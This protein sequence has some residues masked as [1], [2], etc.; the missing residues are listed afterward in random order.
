MWLQIYSTLSIPWGRNI[1]LIN[2]KRKQLSLLVENLNLSLGCLDHIPL[3]KG[4]GKFVLYFLSILF[5]KRQRCYHSF[6]TYHLLPG[7]CLFFIWCALHQPSAWVIVILSALH[8][9]NHKHRRFSDLSK[10]TEQVIDR[11]EIRIYF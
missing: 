4:I 2:K 1:F 3:A 11:G 5:A 8:L 10:M 9:R 6:C 7:R